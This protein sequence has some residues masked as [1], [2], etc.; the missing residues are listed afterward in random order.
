MA[1]DHSANALS[2]NFE[3]SLDRGP[4]A[5]FARDRRRERVMARQ[6]KPGRHLKQV[7]LDLAGGVDPRFVQGSSVT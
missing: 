3:C 2:R 6:G 5:G 1:V 4:V 7:R